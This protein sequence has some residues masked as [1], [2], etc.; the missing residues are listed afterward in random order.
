MFEEMWRN[1]EDLEHHRSIAIM[2]NRMLCVN[3]NPALPGEKG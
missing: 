3:K 2:S 1:E